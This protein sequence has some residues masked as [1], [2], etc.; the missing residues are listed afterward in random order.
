VTATTTI[1]DPGERLLADNAAAVKRGLQG[2]L[3][4]LLQRY[5][6]AVEGSDGAAFW[7]YP[8]GLGELVADFALFATEA[9]AGKSLE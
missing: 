4:R 6:E 1:S 5:V 3:S 8:D 7:T 2:A 9:A